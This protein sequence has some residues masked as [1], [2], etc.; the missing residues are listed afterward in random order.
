VFTY[1]IFVFLIGDRPTIANTSFVHIN[2]SVL[3]KLSL[4]R[5]ITNM[6]M[7]KVRKK[8]FHNTPW[9]HK[10]ERRYCSYP[11]FT[12]SLDGGSV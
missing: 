2:F 1:F 3:I 6:A 12:S 9:R 4:D 10:E 7:F 5:A 8:Q 11:F